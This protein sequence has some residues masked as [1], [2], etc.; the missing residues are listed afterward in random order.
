MVYHQ[1]P[2][3]RQLHTTTIPTATMIKYGTNNNNNNYEL[4]FEPIKGGGG[5]QWKP[6]YIRQG[7]QLSKLGHN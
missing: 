6:P 2:V 3:L 1:F 4:Y 5:E 7:I